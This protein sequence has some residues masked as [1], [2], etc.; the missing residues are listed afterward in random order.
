MCG[1]E[2]G[3]GRRKTSTQAAGVKPAPRRRSGHPNLTASEAV[4]STRH[5][6]IGSGKG[7][8]TMAATVV[9]PDDFV[10]G[11]D[12]EQVSVTYSTYGIAG[13]SLRYHNEVDSTGVG[14]YTAAQI[15]TQ[16]SELGDLVTVTLEENPDAQRR[17]LTLLVPAVYLDENQAASG[18]DI[19]TL[20]I[21]QTFRE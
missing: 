5:P 12:D 4:M 3:G 14:E 17:M 10:V 20:V 6:D 7:E 1:N 16:P 18:I 13:P 15:R 2:G 11:T 9:M 8:S 19:E 21:W